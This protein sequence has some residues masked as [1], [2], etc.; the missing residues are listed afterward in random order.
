[1]M[2][3]SIFWIARLLLTFVI[4]GVWQVQAQNAAQ[5]PS[6]AA[7]AQDMSAFRTCSGT[8]PYWDLTIKNDELKFQHDHM[9]LV[10]ELKGVKAGLAKG[11][12]LSYIALYQGKVVGKDRFLNVIITQDNQCS[13]GR[14]ND[15]YRARVYILSGND[16][17]TGCCK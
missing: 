15:R 6:G 10:M 17:Y 2:Q 1:M 7:A 12:P 3:Q 9:G 16:L 14:S 4:L 11:A 13:D 8:E 5:R